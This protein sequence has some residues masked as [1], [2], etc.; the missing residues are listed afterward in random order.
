MSSKKLITLISSCKDDSKFGKIEKL[1]MAGVDVNSRTYGNTLLMLAIKNNNL[2]LVKLLVK[3]GADVDLFNGEHNA[4]TLAMQRDNREIFDFLLKS[5]ANVNA[6]NSS[7]P[8]PLIYFVQKSDN[9][10]DTYYLEQLINYGTNL[11][12]ISNGSTALMIAC[13]NYNLKVINVLIKNGANLN[14]TCEHTGM[15]PLMMLFIDINYHKNLVEHVHVN[16]IIDFFKFIIDRS[17][18]RIMDHDGNTALDYYLEQHPPYLVFD[19][20]TMNKLKHVSGYNN[21]KSA[22]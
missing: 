10:S 13:C 5:G 8:S 1:I 15:T 6:C 2:N 12:Y 18:V 11:N 4:L 21:T 16:A 22:K 7:S 3:L 9:R 17:N 14:I 20:D 19:I